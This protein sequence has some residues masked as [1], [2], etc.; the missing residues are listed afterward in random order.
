M[1]GFNA[2]HTKFKIAPGIFSMIVYAKYL[3]LITRNYAFACQERTS[4]YFSA[5][6]LENPL[7][8]KCKHAVIDFCLLMLAV[9]VL[10]HLGSPSVLIQKQI[11]SELNTNGDLRPLSFPHIDFKRFQYA[12][13]VMETHSSAKE[14]SNQVA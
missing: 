3:F 9:V 7:L 8:L 4:Y 5:L 12:A 10:E 2:P 14:F 11:C 1:R 6:I 13:W